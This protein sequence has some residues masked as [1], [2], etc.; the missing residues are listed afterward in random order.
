[1]KVNADRILARDSSRIRKLADPW[2]L[3][4]RLARVGADLVARLIGRR[5]L[6]QPH[7]PQAGGQDYCRCPVH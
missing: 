3:S 4:R 5:I 6:A 2:P 1:M 7:S